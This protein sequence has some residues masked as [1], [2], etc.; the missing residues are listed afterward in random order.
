MADNLF[1]YCPQCRTPLEST[2]RGGR[3]RLACPA[4][5]CTYVHWNNPTPVVAAIVQIGDDVVLVRSHGTPES[6]YGL[7]AGFVESGE[8]T[9]QAVLREIDEEI[10]VSVKTPTFL[11]NY[12]FEI[13]NQILF[14]FHAHATSSE[15]RLDTAE[16]AD[17]KRVPIDELVPW[18]R[19]TGL[20]V[21]EWLASLGHVRE[22]VEFGKHID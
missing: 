20:A 4:S 22:P 9:E 12:P 3:L 17:Y 1:K 11:G 5:E 6:W 10:G 14:V 21:R 15:I 16:L 2:E 19:G 8:S 13:R 18:S 7:V